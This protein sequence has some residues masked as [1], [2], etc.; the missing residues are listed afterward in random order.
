MFSRVKEILPASQHSLSKLTHWGGVGSRC[1]ELWSLQGT[2]SKLFLF[3]S[4]QPRKRGLAQSGSQYLSVDQ[5]TEV[6]A[7]REGLNFGTKS[8]KFPVQTLG[9]TA[10]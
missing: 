8:K 4:P 9:S 7:G 2:V 10:E 6:K 1:L 3:V 5:V